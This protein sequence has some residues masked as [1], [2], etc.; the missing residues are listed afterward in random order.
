MDLPLGFG[1]LLREVGHLSV[2][3]KFLIHQW[4]L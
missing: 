1:G 3:P 4:A 2:A